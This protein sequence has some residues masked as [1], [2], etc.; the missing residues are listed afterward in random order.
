MLHDKR[1]LQNARRLAVAAALLLS[2]PVAGADTTVRPN[3]ADV[4]SASFDG[5]GCSLCWWANAFGSGANADT[6]ADLCFTT[7]TVNWQGV[8]LPGLGLKIIRYNIGGGGG[9]ATIDS[10]TI[11]QVSPNMPAFKNLGGYQLNWYSGDPASTSWNWNMD[12]AQRSMMQKAQ[13]RGANRVEFFSNSPLWWMCYNHSTAGSGSGDNNLQSWNYDS[14]AVYLA[15]V[16]QY[17]QSHWNVSVNYVEPFN[18]PAAWWWKYPQG[19]EGCRFDPGLQPTIIASLRAALDSRGLQ[20]VGVTASDENDVDTARNTWNSFSLATQ[21]RIGKVNAHGYAG[22]SPYRGTGRGPLRQAVGSAK[23]WMSE[24]GD[25][26][27]SGLTMADSILRDLTEMRP[28]GWVYWQPFDSGGWGLIQSNPGDNWIGGPNRKWRV[29]AQFSRHIQQGEAILG[30][31]DKNSVVAYDAAQH[32]LKIVTANLGAAQFYAYDLSAFYAVTG[33]VTRWTTTIAP[34]GGTP[35]WAYLQ[36]N[37]GS[38][39]AKTFRAYSYP[40]SVSTFEISGVYLAP[41]P[42]SGKVALEGWNGASQSVTFQFRPTNGSAAFTRTVPLDAAGNFTL[43]NVAPQSYTIAV[44][45]A[46]WLQQMAAADLAHGPVSGLNVT[47][48]AGDANG[49]N[50]C[51]VLDFGILV[52]AYGSLQSDPASGYDVTADFSGDGSVDVLDF[53]LLVNNYGAAGDP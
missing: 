22:I 26:D 18:E 12:A 24:Y 40:N 36:S 25:S 50:A 5:W 43:S 42:L 11:E 46:K 14:F 51:D 16:V 29:L 47:L 33:T 35:D 37:G 49:D 27:G 10:G 4:R 44:K 30:S 41:N 19:Q 38:A 3:P 45:G 28:S 15:T 9:G 13:A 34:T 23:L 21:S 32:K 2:A 31:D 8:A 39:A 52:N 6:L 53:G 7:K 17:A 1:G 48:P 20:S